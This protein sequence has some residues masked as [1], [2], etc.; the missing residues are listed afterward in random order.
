MDLETKLY[1]KY[2]HEFEVLQEKMKPVLNFINDQ[3]ILQWKS[4]DIAGI[5]KIMIPLLQ[6]LSRSQKTSR[7]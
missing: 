1:K 2:R 4:G 6:M 7:R 3:L 5:Q